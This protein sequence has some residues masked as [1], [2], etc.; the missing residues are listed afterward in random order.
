MFIFLYSCE[1]QD[2]YSKLSK[3]YQYKGEFALAIGRS[4]LNLENAGVN[5]PLGWELVPSLLKTQVIELQDTFSFDIKSIVAK[6]EYIESIRFNF[7]IAN[8]FPTK[9]DLTFLI[10]DASAVLIDTLFRTK[11]IAA[12]TYV[13]NN[14]IAST[15]S[16]SIFVDSTRIASWKNARFIIISGKINND[17]ITDQQFQQFPNHKLN[18]EIG[19]RIKFNFN[20][21]DL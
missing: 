21:Q 11:D 12:A 17:S 15:L 5:L 19:A 1:E 16:T 2:D 13:D 8:E 6:N 7:Q 9:S 20:L 18:I 10:T 4:Y 3:N 14:L